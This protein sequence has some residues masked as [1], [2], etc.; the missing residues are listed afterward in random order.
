[1]V[2]KITAYQFS[3]RFKKEYDRLPKKIQKAFNEK[4]TLFLK[5]ISHPSLRIKRIQGTKNRWEGS[6][7]MK[8]RFTFEFLKDEVLFRTIGTHDIL[9]Q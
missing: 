6:V 3:K 9:K 8:Y 1:M 2:E 7:T 4:L 5:E